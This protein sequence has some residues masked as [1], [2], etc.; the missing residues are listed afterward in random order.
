M[1]IPRFL[2]RDTELAFAREAGFHFSSGSLVTWLHAKTSV[3]PVFGASLL[4]PGWALRPLGLPGDSH[5]SRF[6]G[7]P[8]PL[9]IFLTLSPSALPPPPM[10]RTVET[11][12]E[13]PWGFHPC[14]AGFPG[15]GVPAGRLLPTVQ[16]LGGNPPTASSLSSQL[17]KASTASPLRRGSNPGSSALWHWAC[18]LSEPASPTVNGDNPPDV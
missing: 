15:P 12:A 5:L 18:S 6:N 9:S 11:L 2:P 14:R 3:L 1:H 4:L 10:H 8:Q 17:S 16:P 13:R 7:V